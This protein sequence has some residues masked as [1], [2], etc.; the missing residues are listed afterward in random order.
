MSQL[1]QTLDRHYSHTLDPEALLAEIDRLI[2][3]PTTAEMFAPIDQL[4]LGGRSSTIS[5]LDNIGLS[6]GLRVLDIGCGLGG[7]A[8]LIAER[9]GCQVTGV[10]ITAD[11][12]QLA[13]ALNRRLARALPVRFVQADAGRLPFQSGSFDALISQ[14]CLMNLPDPAAALTGFRTLLAT[15]GRLILHEI[16]Q[17]NGG[18]PLYPVPWASDAD[19]SFLIQEQQ[20]RDWLRQTGWRISHWSDHSDSALSWRRHQQN[21]QTRNKTDEGAERTSDK[22]TSPL[23]AEMLFG[24]RIALMARNLATSLEQN[25]VRV[26]TLVAE[27]H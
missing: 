26:I 23:S 21:K 22:P 8:R 15:D 2:P 16:L 4:H 11:F 20:L 17:G 9:Y 10:D 12:C 18:E 13:E 5:L 14:H 19:H 27:P 25:R 6:N 3:E 1:H 7:S 24:P